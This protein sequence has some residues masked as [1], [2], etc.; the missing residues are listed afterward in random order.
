[1]VSVLLFGIHLLI[2]FF[3]CFWLWRKQ[4]D[5]LRLYFW[6][7]L[8]LKLAAGIALGL[9]YKYHY[10]VGDTFGFFEAFGAVEN[11]I[12][13]VEKHLVAPDAPAR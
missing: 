7:A 11:R 3:L 9:L 6:P 4:D 5:Q 13:V 12:R 8:A 10:L 1:M 2:I